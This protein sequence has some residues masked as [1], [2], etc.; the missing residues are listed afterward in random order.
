MEVLGREILAVVTEQ[1]LTPGLVGFEGAEV[2]RHHQAVPEVAEFALVERDADF[3]FLD[4]RTGIREGADGAPDG[5]GN[6]RIDRKHVEIGAV[7]NAHALDR[8]LQ[9]AEVVDRLVKAQRIA[10]VIA[11]EDRHGE[12]GVLDG[13]G[14]RP[15]ENKG[16]IAGKRIGPH[17][18]RHASERGLVAIDVAPRGRDADRAA[19]IGAFG[20][21]QQT[22]G[23]RRCA[24][25]RR[26]A[27]V[28]RHVERIA[29]RAEQVVVGDTAKPHRRRVGLAD[30]DGA[31]AL[32]AFGEHA[33]ER[34]DVVLEGA[35]AAIGR[36]PA[37]LEVE[38]VLDRRR[39]AVQRRQLGTAHHGL[40]GLACRRKRAVEVGE[41]Q[42][43]EAGVAVLD[44]RDGRVHQL[45]R[46]ELAGPDAARQFCRAHIGEIVGG[47]LRVLSSRTSRP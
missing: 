35:H 17:H 11:L 16:Q 4:D 45:Y 44:P 2:E 22:V 46:R 39:N 23:D 21:R 1:V 8:T 29:G 38:E 41:D 47:H 15:L 37:R 32:D 43:V 19:R 33:V 7:G 28:A 24:A 34:R 42:R 9:G 40:F 14:D 13:A 27:G 3:H 6:A 36:R 25:A 30:E 12:C 31:A 18:H 5:F 26:A 20:E 10:R